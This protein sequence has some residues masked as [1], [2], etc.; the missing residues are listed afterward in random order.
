VEVT[1]IQS[2]FGSFSLEKWNV[3]FEG[4]LEPEGVAS[5]RAEFGSFSLEKWN[6]RNFEGSLEPKRGR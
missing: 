1:G 5:T 4:S 6:E 2:I 3:N